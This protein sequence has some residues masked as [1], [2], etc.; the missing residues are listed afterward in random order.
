MST[1]LL[2]LIWVMLLLLFIQDDDWDENYPDFLFPENRAL[3]PWLTQLRILDEP[4]GCPSAYCCFWESLNNLYPLTFFIILTMHRLLML[5]YIIKTIPTLSIKNDTCEINKN[6]ENGCIIFSIL[7]NK[8]VILYLCVSN[9]AAKTTISLI[10]KK[11]QYRYIRSMIWFVR[12]NTN[13]PK[14]WYQTMLCIST[15]QKFIKW[16]KK[17]RYSNSK[18]TKILLERALSKG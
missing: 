9:M 10:Y 2:S 12:K 13:F 16:G 17:E 7:H 11:N 8:I 3:S 5:L 15:Y 18:K 4:W 14:N 6:T 1:E